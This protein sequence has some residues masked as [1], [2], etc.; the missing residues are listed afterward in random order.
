MAF[1]PRCGAPTTA[2]TS[3]CTACGESISPA[4]PPTSAA[5]SAPAPWVARGPPGARREP[6]VVIVLAI[7]TFG[8]YALFYWW[9]VSK[10][11]DAYAGKPGHSHKVVKIGILVSVV[12]GVLGLIAIVMMIGA[13][14]AAEF[15]GTAGDEALFAPLAGAIMLYVFMMI[16]LF[17]GGILLL[18]G[19]YRVWETL[20]QDERARG[21]ASPLSAGL[22]IGLAIGA[23]FVPFA[24]LVLPFVVLYMTTDHLNQ[25]WGQASAVP[26]PQNA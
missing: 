8:F 18:V 6:W 10:E 11:M 24:G 1:C 22:M 4:P 2:T 19:K 7:V 15:D 13:L 9:N 3:F 26:A 12:A 21:H 25:T 16:A 14:F 23:W 17:V 20:E 5:T